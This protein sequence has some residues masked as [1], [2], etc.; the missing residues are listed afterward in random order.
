MAN[1]GIV[2]TGVS[3][4]HLG[5]RLCNAD[6]PPKL[7]AP[8]TPDEIA[9]SR[10][11]NNVAHMDDTLRRER[12]MGI[13]FWDETNSRI[14]HHRSNNVQL[15]DGRLEQSKGALRSLERCVDCRLYLP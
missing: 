8:Q 9:N 6:I 1:I 15:H 13:E 2:G 14:C 7:Y 3:S 10:M 11:T 4:L 12:E 5:I